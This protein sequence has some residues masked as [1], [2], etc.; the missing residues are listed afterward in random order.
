M[1]GFQGI[2]VMDQWESEVRGKKKKTSPVAKQLK[3][4]VSQQRSQLN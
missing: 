1:A 3:D 2:I 4:V